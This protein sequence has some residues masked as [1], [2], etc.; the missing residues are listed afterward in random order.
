VVCGE[1]NLLTKHLIL[2][3]DELDVAALVRS[4]NNR[5]ARYI[6]FD[7]PVLTGNLLLTLSL[8]KNSLFP[9]PPFFGRND[10]L[11]D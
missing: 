8:L 10:D 1:T 11:V 5:Y 7:F 9:A 3:F 4:A 6:T 2:D